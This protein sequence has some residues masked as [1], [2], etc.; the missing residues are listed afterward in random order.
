MPQFSVADDIS[1][2]Y[3]LPGIH[4]CINGQKPLRAVIDIDASQE[5]MEANSVKAQEPPTSLGFEVRSRLLSTEKNNNP[6]RIIIG[7]DILQKCADLVLQKHSNYLRDWT[8]K[9]KVSENFVYFNQKALECPQCKHIHDKDQ[10]WFSHICTSSGMFIVKC[11][12]QNSDEHGKVFECDPSIAEK[13]QK[14][15]KNLS[16]RI[17]GLGFSKAFVKM[18]SWIKY[19]ETLTATEIYEEGYVR[20]LPN[21]GDIYV[22]SP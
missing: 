21:E 11:F 9:E 4:E 5:D 2:V 7:H 1:E 14:K 10:W 6:L 17:K 19:N 20:L 12:Q 16:Y 22:G 13:I 15:N 3:G 8:I 18:P